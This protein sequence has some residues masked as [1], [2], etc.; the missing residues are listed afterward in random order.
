MQ[1][2]DDPT[3]APA[4][5]PSGHAGCSEELW[6][7]V[8]DELRRLARQRLGSAGKASLVP[9]ELVHEAYLRLNAK[10]DARWENPGHFFGAAAESMRRI[11]VDRARANGTRKRGEGRAGGSIT[12][13]EEVS[14]ERPDE[15]LALDEALDELEANDTRLARVVKL[16][17]FG[18]LTVEQTAAALDVTERTV[19]RD[20]TTA[21]AWL[22]MRIDANGAR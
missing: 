5:E 1:D 14:D 13:L 2:V 10:D 11:L 9:T 21:R 12:N 6:A 4:P 19:F 15:L 18:G 22:K 17:Y 7:T 8:Y 16:R 20:W 3:P